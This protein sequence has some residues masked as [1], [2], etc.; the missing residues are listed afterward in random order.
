MPSNK[1]KIY[2]VVSGHLS[3]SVFSCQ[4]LFDLIDHYYPGTPHD[5]IIPSDYLYLDAVK[6][7]PSND[8]NRGLDITYPRF[9]ERVGRNQYRFAGWDGL[10]AGAISAPILRSTVAI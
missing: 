3:A 7:D 9:L 10:P 4:D 8:G 5:S 2:D 6:S 1:Q